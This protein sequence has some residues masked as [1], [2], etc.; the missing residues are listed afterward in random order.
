LGWN[1]GEEANV[2][3]QKGIRTKIEA[4]EICFSK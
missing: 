4:M 2:I 3:I 1:F